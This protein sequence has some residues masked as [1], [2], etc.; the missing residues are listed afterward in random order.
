MYIYV[1]NTIHFHG[2]WIF[3]HKQIVYLWKQALK[4][5]GC[6]ITYLYHYYNTPTTSNSLKVIRNQWAILLLFVLFL[7]FLQSTTHTLHF[8]KISISVM[9]KTTQKNSLF[10]TCTALIPIRSP[11]LPDSRLI[12]RLVYHSLTQNSTHY[13][14]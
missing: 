13:I 10:V 11:I 8:H 14:L 6:F 12:L 4:F 1:V 5:T 2:I 7:Q 3:H 9:S